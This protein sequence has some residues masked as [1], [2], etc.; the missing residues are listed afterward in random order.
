MSAIRTYALRL[1]VLVLRSLLWLKYRVRYV[2]LE[3]VHQKLSEYRQTANSHG[4]NTPGIL[5]LPNHP[6]VLVDPLIVALPFIVPYH[7]RPLITE[8]MFFHPLFYPILKRIGALP[9]P[10]FS[11]GVNSVKVDRLQR[12]LDEV[13]DGLTCGESFLL[14]PS[15]TTKVGPREIIG[16][17]F[18]AYDLLKK[19]PDASIVLVRTT[20]LWGSRFSRAH[21]QGKQVDMNKALKYG[22]KSLFKNFIFFSPR[23]DITVEFEVIPPVSVLAT[24][25]EKNPSVPPMNKGRLEFNKWL[26]RWYNQPFENK[27]GQRA[28]EPLSL[29]RESIWSEELPVL[30]PYEEEVSKKYDIPADIQQE[31]F[32]KIAEIANCPVESI[33]SEQHLVADIGLDSLNIAELITYIEIHYNQKGINPAEMT[34]VLKAT[35]FAAGL[36]SSQQEL[37]DP[38]LDT[39]LWEKAREEKR[40][41]IPEG[42]TVVDAF[43]TSAS[44]SSSLGIAGDARSGIVTYSRIKSGVFLL[45]REIAKYEGDNIGILLPSSL[46]AN[47]L[48]LATQ[49]AGKVPVMINWTVGANHLKAVVENA[50]LKTVLT[51]WSFL[52]RLENVDLSPLKH[53]LVILEEAKATFSWSNFF[54]AKISSLLPW[55]WVKKYSSFFSEYRTV[56]SSSLAVM[57][58]TSGTESMP[59]GVPL[60]HHNILSNLRATLHSIKLYSSDRVLSMLPPFHSFGFAITGLMP[61]LA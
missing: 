6:A 53:Q 50:Q 55:E 11:V 9:V 43:M 16:G 38:P 21:T 12:T 57:L 60:T 40:L 24:Y 17:A 39:H 26:E 3:R 22:L 4:E 28:G 33:R 27:F 29:V 5:F 15:G 56:K 41:F 32:K 49:L 48:I 61:L 54:I 19:N 44:H 13:S 20:G 18:A 14:Y 46:T 1:V 58:F 7:I 35:L 52:D 25:D 36:L 30:L 31:V 23:R 10:N 47:I 37:V 59:K 2:G 34:S 51:S 8:Y 45:A 42:E